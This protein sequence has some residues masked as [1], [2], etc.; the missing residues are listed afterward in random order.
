[1]GWEEEERARAAVTRMLARGELRERGFDTAPRRALVRTHRP[2]GLEVIR[3]QPDLFDSAHYYFLPEAAVRRGA[4]ETGPSGERRGSYATD[5]E[6]SAVD[7]WYASIWGGEPRYLSEGDVQ[8]QRAILVIT[9]IIACALVE[10][11]LALGTAAGAG[12]ASRLGV[13]VTSRLLASAEGFA[14]RLLARF[15]VQGAARIAAMLRQAVQ[16]YRGAR[17]MEAAGRSLLRRGVGFLIGDLGE[18]VRG[19]IVRAVRRW[20]PPELAEV[21]GDVFSRVDRGLDF[22]SPVRSFC[23]DRGFDLSG[24]YLGRFA[25]AVQAGVEAGPRR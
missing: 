18:N 6:H 8:V 17:A 1:M 12:L 25:D 15:G 23:E 11:H 9:A 14:A 5:L 20:G 7:L 3:D 2:M 24:E 21:L 10:A 4:R 13:S 16:V 19:E 22:I